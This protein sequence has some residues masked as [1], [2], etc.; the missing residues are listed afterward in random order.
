MAQESDH[1]FDH[2]LVNNQAP[3]RGTR[4]PLGERG[5]FFSQKGTDVPGGQAVGLSEERGAVSLGG[6]RPPELGDGPLLK[7]SRSPLKDVRHKP[8]L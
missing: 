7:V 5:F 8:R 1:I 3:T 4:M 2:S 6:V